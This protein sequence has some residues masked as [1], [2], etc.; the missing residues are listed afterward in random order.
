MALSHMTLQIEE[1]NWNWNHLICL[2]R[3]NPSK[4]IHVEEKIGKT[5]S[6]NVDSTLRY[7]LMRENLLNVWIE[8]SEK[9]LVSMLNSRNS[10]STLG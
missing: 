8:L 5:S 6:Q 1:W 10:L 7:M 4:I 9:Q 3:K 2:K